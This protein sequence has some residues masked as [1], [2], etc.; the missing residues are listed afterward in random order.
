MGILL[1]HLLNSS[2]Y[3]EV[4]ISSKLFLIFS[5]SACMSVDSLYFTFAWH[6]LLYWISARIPWKQNP[7]RELR[8]KESA[9][10]ATKWRAWERVP[11]KVGTWATGTWV[12]W[13]ILKTHAIVSPRCSACLWKMA[14]SPTRLHLFV[15]WVLLGWE[16]AWGRHFFAFHLQIME[17]IPKDGSA[18]TEEREF[19][20]TC[21]LDLKVK[22]EVGW[23]EVW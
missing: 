10:G 13:D 8:R 14:H 18:D 16:K 1:V 20:G 15:G 23:W 19:R 11:N 7:K 22:L 2:F 5:V 4:S 3:S 12:H 21:H 9:W 6:L 17:S